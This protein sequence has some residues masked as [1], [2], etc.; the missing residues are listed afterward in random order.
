MRADQIIARLV[1]RLRLEGID[2]RM[3]LGGGMRIEGECRADG[4]PI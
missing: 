2:V 3:Q 4:E 1:Y